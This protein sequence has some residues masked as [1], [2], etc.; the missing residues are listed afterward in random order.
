MGAEMVGQCGELGGVA[1]EAF[2]LVDGED[3]PA[4]RGVGLDLPGQR[5]GRLELRPHPD[6]GGD[7][8]REGLVAG[9]AVRGERVRLRLLLLGQGAAA[10]VPDPDARGRGIGRQG[11]RR[12][13]ARAPWLARAAVGWSQHP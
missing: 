11:C 2:H 12:W 1:A 6:S 8:L 7:L 5:E 10:G 13:G 9:D 3:D 4:M